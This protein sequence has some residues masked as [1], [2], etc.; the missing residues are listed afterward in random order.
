[1]HN[2]SKI[3]IKMILL[4]EFIINSRTSVKKERLSQLRWEALET[5]HGQKGKLGLSDHLC[6]SEHEF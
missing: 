5:W 6:P 2:I 3:K 4:I 1:M